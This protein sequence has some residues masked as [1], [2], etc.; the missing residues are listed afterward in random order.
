MR[1]ASILLIL[2]LIILTSP[3][4]SGIAS[5][6]REQLDYENQS[7]CQCVHRQL[8]YFVADSCRCT[9]LPRYFYRWADTG[10][11]SQRAV[12]RSLE[13]GEA[14]K[15]NLYYR[16]LS[17][18]VIHHYGY[19]GNDCCHRYGTGYCYRKLVSAVCSGYRLSGN[20]YHRKRHLFQYPFRKVASKRCRA[21]SC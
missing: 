13:Y 19:F 6:F 3:L 15:E 1:G 11:Q 20:I 7:A 21:N 12:Y 14:I 16:D 18:G 9:T 8:Y 4:F 5:Y 17:R 2:F 10:C